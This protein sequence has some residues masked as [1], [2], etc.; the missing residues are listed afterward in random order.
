MVRC[1][2]CGGGVVCPGTPVEGEVVPVGV[3]GAAGGLDL[4][5]PVGRLARRVR[6]DE[7]LWCWPVGG[8][9]GRGRRTRCR[10]A[11]PARPSP[12]RWP[13]HQPVRPGPGLGC[14]TAPAADF[15]STSTSTIFRDLVKAPA[16][17][18]ETTPAPATSDSARAP[19]SCRRLRRAWGRYD[20]RTR[21]LRS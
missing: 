8:A 14:T 3:D 15:T 6:L 2:V 10:P 19:A 12:A 1:V 7:G 16:T 17:A 13:R 21:R 18:S 20:G 9:P 4:A 11:G 5:P